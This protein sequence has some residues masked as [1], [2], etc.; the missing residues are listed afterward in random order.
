M[1]ARLNRSCAKDGV[2]AYQDSESLETF[3]YFPT[4]ID[5]VSGETIRNYEVKYYGINAKPYFIDVGNRNYQ[6]VVGAVVSGQGVA[7]VTKKQRDA[8]V[9][10][11]KRKYKVKNV[12]LVPLVLEDVTVQ[13]I[14][15][16]D[17]VEIGGRSSITFPEHFQVGTQFGFNVSSGNSLFAELVGLQGS[18]EQKS[19]P[20]IGVNF[21]GTCEL[22]ADPWVAELTADLSQV[23]EYTRSQFGAS[24][25]IGWLNIGS[26]SFDKI[27]QDMQKKGIVKI[28]YIQGGGGKEFGWQLL[29]STKTLFEAI[30]QQAA[31]GEGLFKFEPNPTPQE[32]PS[33]SSDGL[34]AGLLP[35]SVS[36]N[37]SFASNTFKQSIEFKN[38]VEFEGRLP[39]A[40]NGNMAL[41]LPCTASTQSH[42]YD[43]Q[44]K[45][46]GCITKTKSDGLQSRIRKEVA[47]KD[48]KVLEY[49]KK[50]E[51]GTW[52]VQQF[53]EM[54]E[55]LNTINLTESKKNLDPA[56]TEV[57]SEEEALHLLAQREQE[58][59]A[60]WST[61]LE[62]RSHIVH[63][64]F[65]PD[66]R[67]RVSNT[68]ISPWNGVGMLEILFPDGQTY[69]GTATL[70]DDTHVATSAHNLFDSAC[71]GR[72]AAIRF[73]PANNGSADHPY[74]RFTANKVYYPA[75]F[76]QNELDDSLDYGIIRL[77]TAVPDDLTRY[78]LKV[79]AD[80][81]LQTTPVR[82]AGYPSDKQP[83]KTMWTATGS[84]TDVTPTLLGY[85][86]STAQGQSGSAI[87]AQDDAGQW[88]I[89]GIHVGSRAAA[90]IGCRIN[91]TVRANMVGWIEGRT[92]DDFA[93]IADEWDAEPELA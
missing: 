73:Y 85:R 77:A 42:F 61:P 21:Y 93:T 25:R 36:I 30:N 9:A 28:K 35:Y 16:T 26:A 72:A 53:S 89:Y 92:A 11:A 78:T 10:E 24:A 62:S 56:S 90:N 86:I 58:L 6:S 3:H 20:D 65:P 51:D 54:L 43:L 29:E 5:P 37:M 19:N 70:V 71:G 23:W 47:A 18:D 38:R 22:L 49:L 33:P 2:I 55:L 80:R 46:A 84:L 59:V 83:A 64:V 31:A 66:T 74:G 45:A 81:V 34:G 91:E 79:A 87:V 7:D 39:V 57:L 17:V 48:K 32:P 68:R 82:I 41:A 69:L 52:T 63:A 4:R 27:T 67:T 40:F 12:S 8:I 60:S 76:E 44:L 50:V 75:A 14:I 1:V 13:P 15:A 88:C